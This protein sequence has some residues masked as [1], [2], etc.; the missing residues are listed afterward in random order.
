MISQK[1]PDI[2]SKTLAKHEV[3]AKALFER[4][5]SLSQFL[6]YDEYLREFGLFRQKDGSLGVVYEVTL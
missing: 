2:F 5:E 6:P 4:P 1:I 3:F